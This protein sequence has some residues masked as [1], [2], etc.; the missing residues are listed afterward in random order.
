MLIM[1]TYDNYDETKEFFR[2]NKFFGG[3]ESSFIFFKQRML[4]A[5]D[6]EGKIYMKSKSEMSLAPNG[7]GGLLD[8]IAI[9][10]EIKKY[11]ATVDYMQIIGVDNVLNKILDPV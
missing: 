6:L 8:A 10:D 3:E 9:D 7:N 11:I 5:V 2:E 4:P 1:T